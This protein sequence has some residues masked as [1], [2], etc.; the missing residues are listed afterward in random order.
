[1]TV[2]SKTKPIPP[3]M[4]TA[5]ESKTTTIG[6]FSVQANRLTNDKETYLKIK[7][8]FKIRVQN[9]GDI[10]ITVFGNFY[11]PSYSDE[12]FETGDTNLGFNKDAS[13]EFAPH[14]TGNLI[15]IVL[16]TYTKLP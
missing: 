12:T 5:T 13:I 1:M 9:K 10:G 8:A 3:Y 14:V 6:S 15:D 4:E 11:L 7:G 16:T 2:I